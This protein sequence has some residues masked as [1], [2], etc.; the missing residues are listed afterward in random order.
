MKLPPMPFRS[1]LIR[2]LE[3]VLHPS[4]GRV[5]A[6]NF[7]DA[8]KQAPDGETVVGIHAADLQSTRARGG[9]A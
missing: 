8:V 4:Q 5:K 2:N 3:F 9:N 6:A 1:R 7:A